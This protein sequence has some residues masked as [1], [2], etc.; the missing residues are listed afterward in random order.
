MEVVNLSGGPDSVAWSFH[1]MW[2]YEVHYRCDD[3]QG[4]PTHVTFDFGIAQ[5]TEDNL[6]SK[7]DV[8]ILRSILLVSFSSLRCVVMEGSWISAK[9]QQWKN[10]KKDRH[11]FWTVGYS[12]RDD[13]ATYNPYVFPENICQV[14]F[15]D[16]SKDPN[17]KVV[18]RHE[19]WGRRTLQDR[20]LPFFA[21]LGAAEGS[22]MI[23]PF[24]HG[25]GLVEGT[26]LGDAG[27]SKVRAGRIHVLDGVVIQGRTV[28][29]MDD[30]TSVPEGDAHF[31]DLDH[32]DEIDVAKGEVPEVAL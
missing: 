7:I 29:V 32:E 30:Y 28:R 11:G 12:N 13:N 16:D 25:R 22:L 9:H 1:S 2:A 5:I 19:P 4:G 3:E 31:D 21:T 14:F 27:G 20:D 26:A 15:V 10:I 6:H 18:L 17:L 24:N 23:P 8:G